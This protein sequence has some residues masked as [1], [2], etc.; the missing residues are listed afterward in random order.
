MSAGT[1]QN[2]E[3]AQDGTDADADAAAP[4]KGYA[5]SRL[6][7]GLVGRSWLWFVVGCLAVTLVPVLFGW[8]PYVVESGSMRPRVN[9]G[10]VVLASP[11]SDKAT[12]LGRVIVFNSA[13]KKGEIVAHRVIRISGDLLTTKGDANQIADTG[14]IT[15]SDVRG[16]GRLLVRWV[17]LPLIWLQT[18]QWLLLLGFLASLWL[19]G[20]AVVRD[21][22]DD[23]DEASDDSGDDD[24][25]RRPGTDAQPR[26]TR[27]S[28]TLAAARRFPP[29][30][31][32]LA[33]WKAL[34][35]IARLALERSAHR[36]K[37]RGVVLRAALVGL[38]A[39]VLLVPSA[40][41]SFAATTASTTDA[42][43][44]GT[45]DYGTKVV[46][47]GPYLYWRLDEIGTAT[48]AADSSGNARTGTYNLSGAATYFTRLPAGGA[49]TSNTPNN[50]VTLTNANSCINTTSTTAIAAPN[51][52]SEII[53]FK[54]PATYTT[55]G[56]LIGF[57]TPRT[58][59]AVAGG[60]GTYDRHLYMDGNGRIWFGVYNGAAIAI[61]SG[62]G[63][64]N[65]VWH[66]AASTLG[67]TGM[68]LY[69]DG[70]Q[71]ASNA[72]NTVGEA[73][74]GWFRVGCGNLAG[75]GT[76]NW[77]GPNSPGASSPAQNFPFLGAVDEA[78]V[79]MSQLTAA[80]IAALYAAR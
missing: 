68:H 18:R 8:R 78:T 1:A 38:A 30:A 44:A 33:D 59:I 20:L 75:W 77:S 47:L 50:A 7:A 4:E 66:M 11:V 13:S 37:R 79:F 60:G 76:P 48:T 23:L 53:W 9:I 72:G 14:K 10:D 49:L 58:G 70:A 2:P 54:A 15:M 26:P 3:P 71:V 27:T 80:Q 46:A 31:R 64:N 32:G 29:L 6:W 69:I 74:T 65:G 41:A 36:L 35:G 21:N 51:T 28:V 61:S 22:E 67:P 40:M 56:K 25:G 34:P 62:T 43:T 12:V 5:K 63:L 52:V 55:G 42:W 17:G 24:P 57:E 45:Y 16:L 19:A 73:T 39:L